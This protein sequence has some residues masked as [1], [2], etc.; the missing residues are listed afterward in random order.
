MPSSSREPGGSETLM[1]TK[2]KSCGG[3][4]PVGSVVASM[5]DPIIPVVDTASVFQRLCSTQLTLSRYQVLKRP[6]V[7]SCVSGRMY[8]DAIMG[9]S[10]RAT[11]SENSTAIAAVNP[12]GLKNSPG[13]PPMNATGMNTAHSVSE[14]ATTASPISMAASVAACTGGLPMRR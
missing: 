10:V 8:F 12:K 7:S 11:S 1:F 4:K 2:P 14:V 13:M 6:G 9:V 3:A 5:N